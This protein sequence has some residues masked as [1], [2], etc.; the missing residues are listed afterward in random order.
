[1]LIL[2]LGI[3]EEAGAVD[4][5]FS[6]TADPASRSRKDSGFPAGRGTP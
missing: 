4:L 6:G 3:A 2:V 5:N 1:M